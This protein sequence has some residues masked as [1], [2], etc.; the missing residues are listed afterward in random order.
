MPER[1]KAS[2]TAEL[3]PPMTATFLPRKKNPSQVAQA[4]TPIPFER[5]LA[6]QT[7]PFRLCAGREDDALRVDDSARVANDAEWTSACVEFN[8]MFVFQ[9]GADMLGLSPELLHQPRA[10]DRVGEGRDNSPRRW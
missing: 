10:L 8:D 1:Y 6:G 4:E 5:L 3:P 2:S 7:Q 9:A